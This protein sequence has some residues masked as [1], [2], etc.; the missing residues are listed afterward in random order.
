MRLGAY[1]C[2]IIPGTKMEECYKTT[3]I[4]E[5]HRHRYE[6]NNDYRAVRSPQRGLRISGMSP[7]GYIVETVEVPETASTSACSS[8]PNS[9]PAPTARIRFSSDLSKLRSIAQANK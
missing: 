4:S 7:D 5:R 6:F 2:R 8:I 9:S 3:D 1:P